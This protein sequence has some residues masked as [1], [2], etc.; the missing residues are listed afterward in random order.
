[1]L[2]SRLLSHCH[3]RFVVYLSLSL[4]LGCLLSSPRSGFSSSWQLLARVPLL[5]PSPTLGRSKLGTEAGRR[6]GKSPFCL[7][8]H[9]LLV[10]SATTVSSD[11]SSRDSTVPVARVS[12]LSLPLS[13]L[14]RSVSG[15]GCRAG[16]HGSREH[17][18]ASNAS[19]RGC[20][21]EQQLGSDQLGCDHHHHRR[22]NRPPEED[23]MYVS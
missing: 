2:A 14:P 13:P 11:P 4:S 10:C 8:T 3:W 12:L 6:S 7:C 5:T 15:S 19:Q 18:R 9:S 16:T 22:H 20:R 23:Q 1:M 17:R 21:E